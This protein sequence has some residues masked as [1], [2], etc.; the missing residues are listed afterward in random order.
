MEKRVNVRAVRTGGEMLKT[1]ASRSRV[2]MWGG[3]VSKESRDQQ[4]LT[5]ELWT[6][7]SS[8]PL[9]SPQSSDITDDL[10]TPHKVGSLDPRLLITG[11]KVAIRLQR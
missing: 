4:N 5:V 6:S 3:T 11:R 8:G 1:T 9:S 7:K 10:T 2:K